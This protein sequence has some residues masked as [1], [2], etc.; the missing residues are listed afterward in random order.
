MFVARS[1]RSSH[2]DDQWMRSKVHSH[3]DTCTDEHAAA[4]QHT[5]SRTDE[6][7]AANQHSNSWTDEHTSANQYPHS[8]AL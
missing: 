1:P 3:F 8:S 7:A 2:P 6:H 5:N 4:N